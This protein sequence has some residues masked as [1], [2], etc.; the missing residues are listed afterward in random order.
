MTTK[1][2]IFLDR[3][4][5][6]LKNGKIRFSRNRAYM[7]YMRFGLKVKIRGVR[8]WLMVLAI[9]AYR[10]QEA[11]LTGRCMLV[12]FCNFNRAIT[13]HTDTNKSSLH[14]PHST[15]T[16]MNTAGNS[17]THS[18]HNTSLCTCAFSCHATH[19]TVTETS[20]GP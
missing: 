11:I 15:S 1:L 4:I 14:T 8:T 2:R 13:Q 19:I 17:T 5:D 3:H 9:L 20:R 16:I 7:I 18:I 12:L 6:T 10:S